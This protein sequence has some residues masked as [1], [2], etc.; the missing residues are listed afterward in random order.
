VSYSRRYKD[1]LAEAAGALREAATLTHQ[2]TLRNYLTLRAQA[3]LDDDYYASDV[4]FVGLKGPIDVVLGPYEIAAVPFPRS[5][6][7]RH[8]LPVGSGVPTGTPT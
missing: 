2:A 5:H 6:R 1:A 7:M 3:L 8:A 4:A